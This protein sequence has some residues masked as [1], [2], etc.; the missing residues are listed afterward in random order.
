MIIINALVKRAHTKMKTFA[1]IVSVIVPFA[2][3]TKL[4]TNMKTYVKNEE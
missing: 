1:F 3:I 4:V 2:L